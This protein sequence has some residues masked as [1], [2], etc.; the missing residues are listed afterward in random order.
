[1]QPRA[2]QRLKLSRLAVTLRLGFLEPSDEGRDRA[3]GGDPVD[4]SMLAGFNTAP[5]I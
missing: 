1:V 5:K 3:G 4:S 2:R